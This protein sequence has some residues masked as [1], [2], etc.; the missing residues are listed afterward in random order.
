MNLTRMRRAVLGILMGV[1]FVGLFTTPVMAVNSVVV[2]SDTVLQSQIRCSLLV[3]PTNDFSVRNIVMPFTVREVTTGCFPESL[4]VKRSDRLLTN[5]TGINVLNQVRDT[6][7]T[8]CNPTKGY[9]GRTKFSFVN[10]PDSLVAATAPDEGVLATAGKLFPTDPSMPAG[11]DATGSLL[12]IFRTPATQGTFEVDTTCVDQANH[13]L[14][15]DDA[16]AGHVPDFTKGRMQVGI[17][18]VQYLG[19]DGIPRDYSLDQNY[20]NP[21]NASTVIRFNTKHDGHVRLDIFNILGQ[22][23]KTLVDE[24][25]HFGPQAA[26]W[27]GT[28][29]NGV[30]V[31]TGLYFYRLVTAD[32]S[33]VKKMVLLK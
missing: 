24:Y 17:T 9:I 1:V 8:I 19:G 10:K 26:D 14:F 31:P 12:L 29:A 21:F 15:V 30:S 18:A 20:P 27:D 5:L 33:D 22:K 23:V 32:Y 4:F 13:L 2:S 6:A 28:D 3:S 7:S 11:T 16:N 25:R